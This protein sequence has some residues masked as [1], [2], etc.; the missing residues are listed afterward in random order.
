MRNNIFG[1]LATLLLL[2]LTMLLAHN[3]GIAQGKVAGFQ[4]II[5]DGPYVF[6][7][8]RGV[9]M[10]TNEDIKILA[11]YEVVFY[12][13]QQVFAIPG[14]PYTA[15]LDYVPT[16]EKVIVDPP[17]TDQARSGMLLPII[18]ATETTPDVYRGEILPHGEPTYFGW[19]TNAYGYLVEGDTLTGK[20]AY[21]PQF[22]LPIP[23]SSYRGEQFIIVPH[24]YD[25]VKPVMK[26]R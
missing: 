2:L 12:Q 19:D 23:D 5:Y 21:G 9:S 18:Y 4:T 15:I 17:K 26:Q 14:N 7:V 11:P 1:F 13:G 25:W 6:V 3:R 24:N 16:A 8:Y 10:E 22:L 20:W